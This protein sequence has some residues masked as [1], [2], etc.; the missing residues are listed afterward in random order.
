MDIHGHRFEIYTL[1]SEIHKN[2]NLVLG[3]KN[4]FKLE[5][6]INLSNCCFKF[7][8]RS[9]PIYPEKEIV[10]KPNKQKLVKVKAPFVDVISGMAIIKILDSG[11]CSTLLIKSKFT[12][13]KAVLDI[14]NKG[15]E[16]MI[17]RQEEMIGIIDLRSL[18]YYK[19]KQGILQQNLSRYY[20]FEKAEK[21]CE[22]FKKFV[23]TLR[24]EREQKLPKDNY[25]WLDP[26][27]DRRHMTDREI[28]EKY[29]N[30]NNSCLN[31]EEKIKVMD[32]LF[33]YK[34]AFSLRDEIDTCPNIEIE[35][36]VTDKSPFL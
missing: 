33:K 20:R 16:T 1:V 25:P 15:K 11:T 28:L 5:G 22:Y 23:N 4:V 10:L 19:V 26:D 13:I 17:F 14:V 29:I 34:E 18:G 27:D 3:I 9:V 30:L 2:V 8:N 32:M 31:K 24:K 7:L 21:L 35:I 12:Y 6:V 36:D